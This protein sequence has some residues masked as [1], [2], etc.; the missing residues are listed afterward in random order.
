MPTE[1]KRLIV[2]VTDEEEERIKAKAEEKQAT[3]STYIRQRL[4]LKTELRRGAPEGNRN[5]AGMHRR[6]APVNK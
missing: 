3:V 6:K 1:L 4:G 5:A 2:Y